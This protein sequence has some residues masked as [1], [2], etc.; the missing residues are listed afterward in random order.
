MARKIIVTPEG[1]LQFY[2][3]AIVII[4]RAGIDLIVNLPLVGNVIGDGRIVQENR[5]LYI[6]DGSN[7]QDEGDI[8]DISALAPQYD[9]NLG[10]YIF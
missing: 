4:F 8:I 5:H 2:N 9:P 6:W 7:W 3:D 1:K 10:S